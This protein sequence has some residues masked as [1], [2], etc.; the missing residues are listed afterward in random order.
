MRHGLLQTAESEMQHLRWANELLWELARRHEGLGPYVP[1]L[2]PARRMPRSGGR[3]RKRALRRL[4]PSAMQ[5]FIDAERPSG[6]INSRYARVVETLA[7]ATA[8]PDLSDLVELAS[9]VS[10]D[11]I[12]HFRRFERMR[13]VLSAYEPAQ[14]LRPLRL[15]SPDQAPLAMQSFGRI[16]TDLISAYGLMASGNYGGAQH[17]LTAAIRR[18]PQL[19]DEGEAYAARGIGIPFWW[20]A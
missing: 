19:L 12:Q 8:P 11:G 5:E 9:H 2:E 18:M 17:S 1:E 16:K 4:E 13:R 10:N 14:Y 7:R 15:D 3:T 6:T 20:P